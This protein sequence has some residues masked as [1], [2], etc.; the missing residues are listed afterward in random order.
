MAHDSHLRPITR[1]PPPLPVRLLPAARF[2]QLRLAAGL[3]DEVERGF[4]G[5]AEPGEA[6]IGGQL[7]YRGSPACAPR[8]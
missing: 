8:V 2:S 3:V 4:G 1:P 7:P 6:G 5:A